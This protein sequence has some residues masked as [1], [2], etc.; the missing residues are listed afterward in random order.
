MNSSDCYYF[1]TLFFLYFV[2]TKKKSK[3]AKSYMLQ[4]RSYYCLC[5]K[6]RFLG[7]WF[8]TLRVIILTVP[9]HKALLQAMSQEQ[10]SF[11]F[12]VPPPLSAGFHGICR[13]QLSRRIIVGDFFVLSPEVTCVLSLMFHWP[14]LSH[15]ATANCKGR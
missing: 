13:R 15:R 12:V 9:Q 1:Y 2:Y 6:F 5:F 10:S 7:F 14:E 11:H 4:T 8:V 3:K